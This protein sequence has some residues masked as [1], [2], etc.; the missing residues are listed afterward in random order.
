MKKIFE[1]VVE[2]LKQAF[3]SEANVIANEQYPRGLRLYK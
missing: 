1:V 2:V 3:Y